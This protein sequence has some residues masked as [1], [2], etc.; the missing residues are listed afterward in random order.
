MLSDDTNFL[1]D[2]PDEVMLDIHNASGTAIRKI[3]PI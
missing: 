1:D 2:I 3:N